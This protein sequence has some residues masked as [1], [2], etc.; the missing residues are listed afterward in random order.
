MPCSPLNGVMVCCVH[1]TIACEVQGSNKVCNPRTIH[2]FLITDHMYACLLFV[3]LHS[4]VYN[5]REVLLVL[6]IKGQFLR[7]CAE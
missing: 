7:L 6:S 3:C 1:F 5:L 4:T 2:M